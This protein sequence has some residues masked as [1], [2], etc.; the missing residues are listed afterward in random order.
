MTQQT[1]KI[2]LASVFICGFFC[3]RLASELFTPGKT[4]NISYENGTFYKKMSI[5]VSNKIIRV[6][7]FE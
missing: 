4:I 1:Y 2:K 3:N 5:F 7:L 6:I